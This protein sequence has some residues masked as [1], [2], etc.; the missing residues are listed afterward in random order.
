MTMKLLNKKR[1]KIFLLFFLFA[2]V[3]G[4]LNALVIV[5]LKL[6][7]TDN[8]AYLQ[9]FVYE[10]TGSYSFFLLTPFMLLLTKKLPFVKGEILQ[11]VPVYIFTAALLGAIH[12]AVMYYSR[13]LIF[14]W[15][16]WGVY[17][18]GYIPYRYIMETIKLS[19]GFLLVYFVYSFILSN[20]E[21]NEEKLRA[22]KLEEQLTRTRLEFLRNQIHPHFLFNTLNMISSVMYESVPEADKMIADLSDLLRVSL[23]TQGA[24]THSL[25][26]EIKILNYYLDIMQARFKDK[27]DV[28]FE[29]DNNCMYYPVPAFLLQPLVENS[30]K[31][32]M[33]NLS[34]VKIEIGGR[35][36]QNKLEITI[37]DNGP[38]IN[39][40]PEVVL[41]Q[42]VGISNTQERLEKLYGSG[43]EFFWQNLE[44]GGLMVK[45]IITA[46]N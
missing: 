23:K 19:T 18:Y 14:D 5:T 32:G 37:K 40:D 25:K 34:V 12:T 4:L 31:F 43:F 3:N 22:I 15:A 8:V 1:L 13:V 20:K 42:G 2:N 28:V 16:D 45:L 9:Y 6:A 26:E 17:Y 10:F 33:D 36:I 39:K 21:K 24:G 35:L 7:E 27:L 46:N 41:Q 44:S 29:L 30:I 38:G 11:R